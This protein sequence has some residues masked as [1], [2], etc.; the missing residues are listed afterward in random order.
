VAAEPVRWNAVPN[1]LD[2]IHGMR[3]DSSKAIFPT[4]TYRR[5]R[6]GW[7]RPL[8][9]A[10]GARIAGPPV[11]ARVGDRLLAHFKI[12]DR[13]AGHGHSLHFHGVE[14]TASSDGVFV[15]GFSHRDGMAN[16][17]IGLYRVRR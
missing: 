4:T 10:G 17:M 16:G 1:G 11:R 7:R 15:P 6:R 5:Y 3:S 13:L 14:Y 9:G 2:A 8:R 12:L